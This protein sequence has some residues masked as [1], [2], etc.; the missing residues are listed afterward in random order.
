MRAQLLLEIPEITGGWYYGIG[1]EGELEEVILTNAL[2]V[3]R[4][5]A[6][7]SFFVYIALRTKV[8]SA[9]EQCSGLVS[10]FARDRAGGRYTNLLYK[11]N[12]L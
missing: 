3:L 1:E 5:L 2:G 9:R 6:H 11:H 8:T 4:Q 10:V 12:N 7:F